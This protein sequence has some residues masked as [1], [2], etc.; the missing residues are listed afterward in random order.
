[1]ADHHSCA[2]TFADMGGS[3]TTPEA[4]RLERLAVFRAAV[5]EGNG[6]LSAAGVR[7]KPDGR[8]RLRKALDNHRPFHE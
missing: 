7:K 6:S 8:G 3:C 5:S 2:V 4:N 1:M